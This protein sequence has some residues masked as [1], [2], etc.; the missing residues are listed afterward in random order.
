MKKRSN[1]ESKLYSI[2]Q[3]Y[4][5]KRFA[6][7][8]TDINRGTKFGRVDVIG[9]RD[10]G[11]DLAGSYEVIGVEVKAGYQAFGTAA[12]QAYGYSVY[13]H[14][15]YLADL[16]SG[17]QPFSLDE[18]TIASRLGIGLLAIT[19]NRVEEVL[20]AP[21]LHPV[22][23]FQ[24]ELIEKIGFSLCTLCHSLFKRAEGKNW[25]ASISRAGVAKAAQNGKG[26]IYWLEE[27]AERRQDR[28]K[29]SKH[30][31]E[32]RYICPGCVKVLSPEKEF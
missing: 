10:V 6:C 4:V 15:C 16:R 20:A 31:Y 21:L 11:R 5:K 19:Q 18:I 23:A 22:E 1:P 30:I 25:S 28:R 7:F 3:R 14:R 24:L 17:R 13:A 8:A 2:V 32:R 27:L 9:I 29:E 12:G 26:V